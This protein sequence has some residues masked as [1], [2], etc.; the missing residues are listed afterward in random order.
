MDFG[1]KKWLAKIPRSN[2]FQIT[3]PVFGIVSFDS[4]PLTL[5]NNAFSP[6]CFRV[7][8]WLLACGS[9]PLLAWPPLPV[10]VCPATRHCWLG[11]GSASLQCR[12]MLPWQPP[13]SVSKFVN[14]KF[15]IWILEVIQSKAHNKQPLAPR[16]LTVY[17]LS[18]IMN[19]G[20]RY[21]ENSPRRTKSRPPTH[22]EIP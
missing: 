10:S 1:P 5:P 9:P 17:Y 22:Q 11:L 18:E 3:I 16:I 13:F 19:H 21:L 4:W 15:F 2:E 20:A 7:P 14:K 12:E 6:D 8:L